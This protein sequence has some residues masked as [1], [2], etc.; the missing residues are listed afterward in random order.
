M[1]PDDSA[2]RLLEALAAGASPRELR[3]LAEPKTKASRRALE[4]ALQVRA[5]ADEQTERE[6][7]LNHLV[8][9]VRE[10]AGLDALEG[11][12]QSIV[13]RSR[14]LMMSDVAYFLTFDQESFTARMHVSEGII[15]DAFAQLIVPE[16]EGIS[17]FIATSRKPSWTPD[18]MSDPRY[19]H[20]DTIDSATVEEGLRAIIGVPVLR[21]GRVVGLLLAADRHVHNFRPQDVELLFSLAQH[22]GVVIENATVHE[23]EQQTVE[24]LQESVHILQSSESATKNILAFQDRLL[25]LLMNEGSLHDLVELTQSTLGGSALVVDERGRMLARA[26]S[27]ETPVAEEFGWALEPLG[28]GPQDLGVIGHLGDNGDVSIDQ[29]QVLSRSAT[30]ARLMI[31]RLR[32]DLSSTRDK[33]AKLIAELLRDPTGGTAAVLSTT[34]AVDV[35]TLTTVLTASTDDNV[36]PHQ[37]TS[38]AYDFAESR[39]GVACQVDDVVLIWLPDRNAGAIADIAASSLTSLCT[40]PVTVGA[41]YLTGGSTGL[42]AAT[43]EA[44]TVLRSL[45]ALGRNG[46]GAVSADVAPFPTVLANNSPQ[47]LRDFVHDILGAVDDYDAR[48]GTTLMSTLE[49]VYAHGSNVTTAA[50]ALY[51]HPNTVHQRLARIDAITGQ[52]WRD[53]DIAMRRQ[54]GFTVIALLKPSES[55]A[56]THPRTTS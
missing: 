30:V 41:A 49:T 54:L 20:N 45:H 27:G 14:R 18:Y 31:S 33:S 5:H 7:S 29:R 22:A 53:T 13:S 19:R 42:A 25:A 28:S 4:F 2:A 15:S 23:H 52:N 21:S 55:S 34:A 38:A 46:T 12:L 32:A 9:S 44:R 37:L 10:L 35:E 50:E 40:T 47:E 1:S 56:P 24:R 36:D 8:D 3:A 43:R 16:D 39:S 11:V 26:G 17:G 48:H 6:R 51:V